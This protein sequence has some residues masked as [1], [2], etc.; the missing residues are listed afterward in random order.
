MSRIPQARLTR[1]GRTH[2]RR[3]RSGGSR[4]PSPASPLPHA[5]SSDGCWWPRPLTVWRASPHRR[6]AGLVRCGV[7]AR[8]R[9][10][11]AMRRHQLRCAARPRHSTWKRRLLGKLTSEEARYVL[12][13]HRRQERQLPWLPGRGP[14]SPRWSSRRARVRQLL[15]L[16]RATPAA[17]ARS[18]ARE[19]WKSSA[20][21]QRTL[22]SRSWFLQHARWRRR[23]ERGGA[24]RP[25]LSGLA[26]PATCRLHHTA[27]PSPNH[28]GWLTKHA[29]AELGS[30]RFGE[31]A[32]LWL[33]Q[34]KRYVRVY[35]ST[36]LWI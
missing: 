5:V 23:A 21:M 20:V 2:K 26:S 4:R 19:E 29:P 25:R 14:D 9:H 13:G 3:R 24:G 10:L 8:A 12:L 27:G 6:L 31:S 22:G 17:V 18:H 28:G 30:S 36:L 7:P 35:L 1:N 32:G 11:P 33:F 15:A 16:A 34:S